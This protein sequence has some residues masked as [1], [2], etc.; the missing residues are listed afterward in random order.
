[1][2]VLPLVKPRHYSISSAAEVHPRRL[3]LTVGVL[4]VGAEGV[5]VVVVVVGGCGVAA[6]VATD[7]A[8]PPKTK[9]TTN[10]R[11]LSR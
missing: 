2:L 5:V 7:F 3:Q 9:T 11:F 10:F 8:A 4:K 1:M 6:G